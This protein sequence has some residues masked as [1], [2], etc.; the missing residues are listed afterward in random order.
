MNKFFATGYALTTKTIA[1]K[2]KLA[3]ASRSATKGTRDAYSAF[4]AGVKAAKANKV[5]E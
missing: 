5:E 4:V 3:D 1:A 2:A